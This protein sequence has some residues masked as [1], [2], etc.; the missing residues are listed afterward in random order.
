MFQRIRVALLA[1][2]STLGLGVLAAPAA[3]ANVLSVLPGSCG[4]QPESQPFAQWGDVNEYTPVAGGSF[5]TG[6]TPWMLSGGAA[7]S[8]GNETFF[9]NSNSDTHSLSLPAGGSATSPPA[10]TNV[11][12]PTLRLFL[13]NTG[14]ESSRLIVQAIYTTVLG[15]VGSTT[16][17]ELTGTSNWTPSPILS[18]TTVNL[19]ATLSPQN[20]AIAFRFTPTGAGNWSIDDAYIDPYARG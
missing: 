17:G 16:I 10:C 20:T 1:T 7:V 19:M 3:Q 5:E 13:R 11:Y 8:S 4:N 2:L 12:Q 6:S 9:V 15:Q 14:S 18:L